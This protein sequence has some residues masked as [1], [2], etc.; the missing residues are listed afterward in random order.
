[1]CGN[2][3]T[4]NKSP[5]QKKYKRMLKI[6]KSR[7]PMNHDVSFGKRVSVAI[8]QVAREIATAVPQFLCPEAIAAE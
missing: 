2:R 1:M 8:E 3:R 5:R 6:S 4:E 7:A